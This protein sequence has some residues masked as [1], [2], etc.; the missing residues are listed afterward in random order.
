MGRHNDI[1]SGWFHVSPPPT[2]QDSATIEPT[3]LGGDE[4]AFGALFGDPSLNLYGGVA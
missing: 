3:A 4:P 2:E 1:G